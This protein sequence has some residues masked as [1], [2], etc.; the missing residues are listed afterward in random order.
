MVSPVSHGYILQV[1]RPVARRDHIR[2]LSLRVPNL[3]K[4]CDTHRT[5]PGPCIKASTC[6]FG[7]QFS[8]CMF[9]RFYCFLHPCCSTLHSK[10]HRLQRTTLSGYAGDV[11]SKT[12]LLGLLW[13]PVLTAT[14]RQLTSP[15]AAAVLGE[16]ID[17]FTI[18]EYN[19][20]WV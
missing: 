2:R 5:D 17:I 19:S 13:L 16:A 11:P 15:H 9:F 12:D 6:F 14:F 20:I 4:R 1:F 7:A 8:V 10:I 18:A 3:Q